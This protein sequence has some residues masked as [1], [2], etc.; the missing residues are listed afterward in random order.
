MNIDVTDGC[1]DG[2]RISNRSP[3]VNIGKILFQS[4][5]IVR[6]LSIYIRKVWRMETFWQLIQKFACQENKINKNENAAQSLQQMLPQVP[7]IK[8]AN[9]SLTWKG[10]GKRATKWRIKHNRKTLIRKYSSCPDL[11]WMQHMSS[12]TS[13]RELHHPKSQIIVCAR[14]RV[15]V[16]V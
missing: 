10:N 13:A 11:G 9:Q 14:V 2:C 7:F 12:L 16:C 15:C 1:T 8:P 5:F 3:P 6:L 4:Q